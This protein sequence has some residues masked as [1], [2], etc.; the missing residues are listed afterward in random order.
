[1]ASESVLPAT[2]LALSTLIGTSVAG[3]A[4]VSEVRRRGRRNE[5]LKQQLAECQKKLRRRRRSKE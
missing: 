4:T 3:F 1:V 5:E 2:I